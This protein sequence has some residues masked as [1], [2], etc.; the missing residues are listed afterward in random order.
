MVDIQELSLAEV[1]GDRFGRY[2]KYI[3]QDRA[4]P[5][6]RDGLKPVQRR[7]LYAMYREGNTSNSNFRKAAKTVGNVIGNYHPHGDISVYDAMVRMSQEWKNREVLIEMHGNN[8]SMDGDPAAAMR[9][10]EARLSKI[11][12]ELLHDLDKDTVEYML[13]FDDTEEEPTVL[14]AGFPN[15]LV[16]GASGISAGYATEIP[17]HNLGEVIDA[18]TYLIDHPQASLDKLLSLMPGPD[19]PTGAVIQ[20]QAE[21]KKAYE[22]G[23][24]RVV[25]RSRHELESLRSGRQQIVINEIPFEVN[26]SNLVRRMDELRLDHSV[27]GISEIRDE[28]DRNGLRI[29]IELKKEANI[30]AILQYFYKNTDLQVNYNF[31][32]VAI[33]QQRPEQVGL[34]AMLQAFI[35]HRAEIIRRRT[36]FDRNK[37]QRRLHIVDG[38][39][40][41]V[42]ILDEII[43]T[44]RNSKNKAD[45]KKNLANQFEF[46]EVQAE[47]IVS[48]QLY[49][50]TNTDIKSLQD[51][52]LDLNE[53]LARFHTILSDEKALFK[54]MKQ[55]LKTIK[56][57]YASPRRTSIEAEI[58][59]VVVEKQL[60]IPVEDAMVTV[61]RNGYIKR[62]SL[63]S[64]GA[65]KPEEV[66]L[67]EG[68]QLVYM[69]EMQTTDNLIMITS[70]GNYI[71]QPVY[72]LQE[73]RWK[74]L[75]EHASQ[76]LPL[77][78]DERIIFVTPYLEDSQ[79]KL[80]LASQEGMIKQTPL[81]DFKSFRGYKKKMALAMNLQSP[82]DQ[83]IQVYRIEDQVDPDQAQVILF[84][85]FGFALRYSLGEISTVGSRAKGV[86]SINLKAGDQVVG[87]A[88]QNQVNDQAQV[89]VFTQRGH[90]KR[91]NWEEISVLGR[92]KRGLQVL[93]TLKTKPHYLVAAYQI[94]NLKDRYQ[95]YTSQGDLLT[96]MAGDVNLANRTSNGSALIDET[97]H[98][99]V[100]LVTKLLNLF[101]H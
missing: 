53:D 73:I 6:I 78:A 30:D 77:Q 10:T 15:L 83:V 80:L 86:K 1:M 19:F 23:R 37:A 74:D 41:A 13:N 67:R 49:R 98:G 101:D 64:F 26:K 91:M 59:E 24:G 46:S 72:E 12:D 79:A 38:L 42:S 54:L 63:R 97:I 31:N 87:L 52:R 76:R 32:M 29:V 71:Y 65:S 2:S 66:G 18:T 81:A 16:N 17:T 68:D 8:G 3:I 75:G 35:D 48:L 4:L 21:L 95:A 43:T 33:N 93:K 56:T 28:S 90:V 57:N 39:I 20:G 62:S 50:L 60:L 69:A 61:T 34:R 82:S 85:K 88:Y 36:S 14:P 11:A 99:Q 40:K 94:D 25:V 58:E 45:A 92:A 7:I 44:I 70:K 84:S 9:Y 47:A 22:T 5:D 89:I 27:D 51:E 100:I 55:E 96:L